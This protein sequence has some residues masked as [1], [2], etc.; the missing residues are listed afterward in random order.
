MPELPE[1]ETISRQLDPKMAGSNLI[2]LEILDPRLGEFP[3]PPRGRVRAVRRVG[4]EVGFFIGETVFLVHLRMT[5]R[6]IWEADS[7]RLDSKSIMVREEKFR[8][9]LRARLRFDRGVLLFHDVRRFGTMRIFPEESLPSQG[10]DPTTDEF[11]VESLE[12]LLE[13]GSQ[14]MKNFLLRQD[15]IVGIGNIYASE[16]LFRSRL[17]PM[18]QSSSLLPDEI[19]KLHRAIRLTLELAIANSGTTFSDYRDSDGETGSFGRFLHVYDREGEKCRSCR[20]TIARLVQSGRSSFYC[21]E[22]QPRTRTRKKAQKPKN[23]LKK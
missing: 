22:C 23:Q 12:R 13:R 18:R 5:G 19:R 20:E 14:P 15:R 4:K 16:I 3:E 1:V 2:G 17:H 8:M 6:L 11:T 9:H 21:P 7:E 10:I